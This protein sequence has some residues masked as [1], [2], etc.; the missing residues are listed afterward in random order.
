[1]PGIG[2]YITVTL[3]RTEAGNCTATVSDEAITALA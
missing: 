1:L 3:S 2:G